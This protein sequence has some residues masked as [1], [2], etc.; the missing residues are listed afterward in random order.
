T[1]FGPG[2][3]AAP[4]E[5]PFT[6]GARARAGALHVAGAVATHAGVRVSHLYADGPLTIGRDNRIG[7]AEGEQVTLGPGSTVAT[8]VSHGDVAAGEAVT[9][10]TIRASGDIT[11]A[12]S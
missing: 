6:V 12:A 7:Y 11:L 2:V 9:V 1:I 10:D 3:V 8:I 5:Q 4:P